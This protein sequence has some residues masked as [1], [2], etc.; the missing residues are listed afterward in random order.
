[1]QNYAVL[2]QSYAVWLLFL[3][4]L[5]VFAREASWSVAQSSIGLQEAEVYSGAAGAF[6]NALPVASPLGAVLRGYISMVYWRP[7]RVFGLAAQ[8]CDE[9][10]GKL[11]LTC[12]LA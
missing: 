4:R 10:T 6:R 2:M 1:M 7:A 11:R 8:K 9:C 12:Y 3:S 5:A